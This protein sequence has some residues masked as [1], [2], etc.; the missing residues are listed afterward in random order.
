MRKNGWVY[1]Y[2]S[3]VYNAFD[4]VRPALHLNLSSSNLY[5]YAGTVCSDVMKSGESGSDNPVNPGKPEGEITTTP[6]KVTEDMLFTPEYCKYLNNTTYNKMFETLWTD[7]SDV[8]RNCKWDD[9]SIAA[10]TVMSDGI[11]GQLKRIGES[12]VSKA[13]NKN[14]QAE[15][16]QSALEC[17]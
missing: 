7:M 6:T 14:I 10:R 2:G 4:G 13:F 3:D 5:S 12:L 17:V 15:K 1:R 9:I 11:S 16:V 8:S